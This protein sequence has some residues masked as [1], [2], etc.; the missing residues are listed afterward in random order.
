[1]YNIEKNSCVST[2]IEFWEY[3]EHFHEYFTELEIRYLD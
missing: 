2:E 3:R 1:M